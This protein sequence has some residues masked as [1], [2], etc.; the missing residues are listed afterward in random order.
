MQRLQSVAEVHCNHDSHVTAVAWGLMAWLCQWFSS[1]WPVVGQCYA[2]FHIVHCA[3]VQ[4]I[5]QLR[6]ENDQEEP[7]LGS[8]IDCIQVCPPPSPSAAAAAFAV[9][10]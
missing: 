2:G 5:N 9:L 1:L 7:I 6:S 10:N 4:E 8:C 3:T